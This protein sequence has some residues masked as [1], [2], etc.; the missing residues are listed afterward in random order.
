MKDF[1]PK[2]A[3]TLAEAF[4]PTQATI[5]ARTRRFNIAAS[6]CPAREE[7]PR[8]DG[9]R[10]VGASHRQ[11]EGAFRPAD[12]TPRSP[13]QRL[14]RGTTRFNR[15]QLADEFDRLK[16][17][18]RVSGPGAG[19]QTTRPNLEGA[20]RLVAH[21][22][23]E[24]AFPQ[25]E[26]DQLVNQTVTGI[27][28][29]LSE[30]EARASEELSKHFNTYPKGDWRYS[31][32]L[33]ESLAEVKAA[34]LEDARRFHQQFYGA[35]PAEI[36]IVG[37]FDE[38]RV[39]ALLK[40]L[41]EGWTP[42]VAYQ[43][44][45]VAFQPSRRRQGRRH[46][47]KEK[48]SSSRARHHMRGRDARLLALY[49][50]D[51]IMGGGACSIR[52]SRRGSPEGMPLVRRGLGA[53]VSSLRPRGPWSGYASPPAQRRQGRDRVQGDLAR[54][55]K[56]GFTDAEWRAPSRASSRCARRPLPRTARSPTRGEQPLPRPHLRVEQAI[57]GQ[58]RGPQD[59]GGRR[60][61]SKTHRSG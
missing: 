23:K 44:D 8:R 6:R 28:A 46:S 37:D 24:P 54:A 31:P 50:A 48:R 29:R 59:R 13:R 18:G 61:A 47:R 27:M 26:Y 17:S 30:P 40:D 16:V 41:F 34:K 57:R 14:A 56:D 12:P 51:Y 38:A 9:E 55:L 11:R 32:T 21:V 35:S 2:Q 22:L 52:A 36:A 20:L 60:R 58:T 4:E 33:E 3:T 15:G 45:D 5:D 49:V 43:R 19:I 25:A 39:T 53:F 1:R 10:R 42:A 7:E